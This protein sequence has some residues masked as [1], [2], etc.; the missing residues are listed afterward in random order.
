MTLVTEPKQI[1]IQFT[2][3]QIIRLLLVGYTNPHTHRSYYRSLEDFMAWWKKQGWTQASKMLIEQYKAYM[4]NEGVGPTSINLRI[5][6]IKKMFSEA[7]DNGLIPLEIARGI[8]RVKG[9]RW[10]G[11]PTGNW[12]TKEDAQALLDAPN[13]ETLGGLR[14]RAILAVLLGC[15]LRRAELVSLTYEHIQ[16]RDGRWAI[17]DLVGK[18]SKKRTIPMASWTM[19]AI[20]EWAMGA[21]GRI[22]MGELLFLRMQKGGEVVRNDGLT[23][24]AVRYVV[25]KYAEQIGVDI[26]PHDLRRTFAR[27]AFKGDGRLEQ[28][29]LSLGHESVETTMKYVG[30]EQDFV[31]APCDHLGLRL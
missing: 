27:L 9:V 3:R 30:V 12:L 24:D 8:E 18:R 10:E 6:A 20:D 7:Y 29:Q 5:T 1:D 31:D 21:W 16:Q 28:L 17:V 15:G 4:V 25:E 22:H 11:K 19:K 13:I 2:Y 14:D 26:S 23:P